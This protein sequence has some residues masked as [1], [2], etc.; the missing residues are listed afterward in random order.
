MNQEKELLIKV[1]EIHENNLKCEYQIEENIKNYFKSVIATN[2][3]I[4]RGIEK[5]IGGL[6]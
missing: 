5:I 3:A 1:V 6:S 4:T 2:N